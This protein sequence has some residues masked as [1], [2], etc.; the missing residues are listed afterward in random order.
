MDVF[1]A[2]LQGDLHD[3]VYMSLPEGFAS[4][5]ESR[6]MRKY[7]LEIITELG[8]SAS[9]PAWTPL[10][11]NQK[12]TN[13]ELGDLQGEVNDELME[14]KGKYQKLIGKLLYLTLTRLDIAFAVHTLSQFMQNPKR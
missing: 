2:F 1:N 4:H 10:E 12:V 7:A 13:K 9:K 14:N 6:G 3:E 5:G 11:F 8:L